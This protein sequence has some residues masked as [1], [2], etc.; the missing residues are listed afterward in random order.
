[1]RGPT[2]KDL[3]QALG[4]RSLVSALSLLAQVLVAR[5]SDP[6]ISS[7]SSDFRPQSKN[8]SLLELLQLRIC[9][10]IVYHPLRTPT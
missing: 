8:V 7:F 9:F 3:G 1:M 5:A 10:P 4:A 2:G 6:T